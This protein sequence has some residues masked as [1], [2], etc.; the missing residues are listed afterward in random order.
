MEAKAGGADPRVLVYFIL[1]WNGVTFEHGKERPVALVISLK[2]G[3]DFY[4]IC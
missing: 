4:R 2:E 3:N 1:S